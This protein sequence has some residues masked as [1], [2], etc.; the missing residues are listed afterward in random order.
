M[1]PRR[2]RAG[3]SLGYD[4]RLYLPLNVSAFEVKDNKLKDWCKSWMGSDYSSPLEPLDWFGK[5]HQPGVHIW[6]PPPAAALVAM[7]ELAMSRHKRPYDVTHVV[8][9]PRLLWQ[10]EWRRRFEKEVDF[11][12]SLKP[13]NSWPNAAFE[14]LV[15]GISFP[16]IRSYPW[17][18]RLQQSEVVAAGRALSSM[19]KASDLEVRDYLRKL[20]SSPRPLPTV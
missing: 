6:S 10:E 17:L 8:L 20:W 12:F 7:K 19:P 1:V 15:I 11:W 18:V 9:I 5:G 3:I 14:P 4:L 13:C 2:L 16:M